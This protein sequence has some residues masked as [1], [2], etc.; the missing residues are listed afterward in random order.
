MVVPTVMVMV[1][2]VV[3]LV[4]RVAGSPIARHAL[5]IKGET[6]VTGLVVSLLLL[7]CSLVVLF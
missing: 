7:P 5:L 1:T 2:V 4:T 6:R 3:M